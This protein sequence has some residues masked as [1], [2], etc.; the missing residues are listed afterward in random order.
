MVLRY[1][2]VGSWALDHGTSPFHLVTKPQ[3]WNN[4]N[5]GTL[6][7]KQEATENC[8][9]D[10]RHGLISVYCCRGILPAIDLISRNALV[11]VCTTTFL[12]II[13][14]FW[15]M[16]LKIVWLKIA[17]DANIMIFFCRYFTLLDLDY[18]VLSHCSASGLSRSIFL[19]ASFWFSRINI[20]WTLWILCV[21]QVYMY[22]RGSGKAAEMKRDATRGALRSAF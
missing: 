3:D 12:F 22:F 16:Y 7:H 2:L 14:Y 13:F 18:S 10:L 4:I 1:N 11:G 17:V 15:D 20:S 19:S 5:H 6:M 8:L 9:Q 21:Q